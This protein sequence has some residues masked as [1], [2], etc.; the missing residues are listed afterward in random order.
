MGSEAQP[1]M[2][3]SCHCLVIQSQPGSSGVMRT[4]IGSWRATNV[5]WHCRQQLKASE[6]TGPVR[7]ALLPQEPVSTQLS[8]HGPSWLSGVTHPCSRVFSHINCSPP[9]PNFLFSLGHFFYI[10][11][12]MFFIR[13]LKNDKFNKTTSL[14]QEA[15]ATQLRGKRIFCSFSTKVEKM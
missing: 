11:H 1:N 15:E 5:F 14:Q 13:L 8:P 12:F 10:L 2:R 3:K 4:R 7:A 9:L 6:V